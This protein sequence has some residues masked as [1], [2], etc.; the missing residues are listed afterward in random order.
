[1]AR[2]S[3]LCWIVMIAPRVGAWIEIARCW[4]TSLPLTIAPR[5][6]AWI[7][8]TYVF[9]EQKKTKFAPHVGEQSGTLI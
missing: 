4:I 6:G 2:G 3:R 5:V 1:M 9:V 7:E 8:K